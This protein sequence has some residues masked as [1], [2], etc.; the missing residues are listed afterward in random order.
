MLASALERDFVALVGLFN[1]LTVLRDDPELGL[2][3]ASA[4]RGLEL[5]RKLISSLDQNDDETSV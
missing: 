1:D 4:E 3:R 2:I 5:A